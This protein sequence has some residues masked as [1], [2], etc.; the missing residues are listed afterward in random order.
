M[1]NDLALAIIAQAAE[2]Y[3]T[4]K[5]CRCSTAEVEDFFTSEWCDRLIESMDITGKDILLYLKRR[6]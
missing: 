1:W 6:R 4:L 5:H 3:K 2:D